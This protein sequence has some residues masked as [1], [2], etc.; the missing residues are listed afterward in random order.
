MY[1]FRVTDEA[2]FSASFGDIRFAPI[3]RGTVASLPY[4]E[5]AGQARGGAMQERARKVRRVEGRMV[6]MFPA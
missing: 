4:G 3:S 1:A 6:M 5:R 2:E